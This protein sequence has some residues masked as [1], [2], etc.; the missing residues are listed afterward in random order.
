M[1]RRVDI[2]IGRRNRRFGVLSDQPADCRNTFTLIRYDAVRVG[3]ENGAAS[4]SADEPSNEFTSETGRRHI[5]TGVAVAGRAAELSTGVPSNGDRHRE[6]LPRCGTARR[7]A[8]LS[9]GVQPGKAADRRRVVSSARAAVEGQH[10]QACIATGECVRDGAL[11][12]GREPTHDTF[13]V[14]GVGRSA[15]RGRLADL[16]GAAAVAAATVGTDKTSHKTVYKRRANREIARCRGAAD[17]AKVY[18]DEPACLGCPHAFDQGFVRHIDA[19]GRRDIRDRTGRAVFVETDQPADAQIR[20]CGCD[21]KVAGG[22]RA[23]DGS[24]VVT[25]KPACINGIFQCAFHRQ[26]H[27]TGG[28]G[29]AFDRGVFPCNP[30]D[31]QRSATSVCGNRT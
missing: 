20:S 12:A 14:G 1:A 10:G 16:T 6:G 24:D 31:V 8:G 5:A 27:R 19:A 3:V 30:T 9:I 13:E 25:R 28:V 29:D 2:P 23:G 15:G 4:K 17:G 22:V 11:V 21:R 26:S 7:C 18:A